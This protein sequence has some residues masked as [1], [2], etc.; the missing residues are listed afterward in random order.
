MCRGVVQW[1]VEIGTCRGM[2]KLVCNVGVVQWYVEMVA[3]SIQR[4]GCN[5][6][7]EDDVP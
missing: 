5:G 6:L 4:R 3:N 1:Y 7:D 2:L